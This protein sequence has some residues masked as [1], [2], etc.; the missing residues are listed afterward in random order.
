MCFELWCFVWKKLH[1]LVVYY[2]F[3]IIFH[4]TR[5]YHI[6]YT[7]IILVD[8]YKIIYS[9]VRL[10][11]WGSRKKSTIENN[12]L[13]RNLEVNQ[14]SYGNLQWYHSNSLIFL[15]YICY[16]SNSWYSSI[17]LAC[18]QGFSYSHNVGLHIISTY[19]SSTNVKY[20]LCHFCFH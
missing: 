1:F 16:N 5:L 19:G 9:L 6:L 11:V 8:L 3:K 13:L 4:G 15:Q 20:H 2:M 10:I 17:T 18:I 7:Q 14:E 12:G